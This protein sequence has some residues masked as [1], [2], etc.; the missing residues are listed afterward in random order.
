MK[1]RDGVRERGIS[2]YYHIDLFVPA[3]DWITSLTGVDEMI[4]LSFLKVKRIMSFSEKLKLKEGEMVGEGRQTACCKPSCH[5]V[6]LMMI[7]PHCAFKEMLIPC[8]DGSPG[9]IFG[10]CQNAI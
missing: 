2:Q 8:I 3:T 1:E 9:Q 5:R 4:N 10:L 7:G 6:S